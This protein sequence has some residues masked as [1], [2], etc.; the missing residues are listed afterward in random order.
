[1][2]LAKYLEERREFVNTG[3]KESLEVGENRKLVEAMKH[4]PLV[5]GKRLRP[6]LSMLVA[7]AISGSGRKTIQFGLC[8][9]LIH[10]FTLVHDDI[11]DKDELRR[12]IKTVYVVYGTETAINAGDALFARAFE[13]LSGTDVSDEK[14]RLLLQD[15]SST[16]RRV[17]EGQQWDMD[18]EGRKEIGEDEYLRMIE[19][20]TAILYELAAKGGA[21]IAGGTD[22]QVRN[23]A[24]YGRLLGVGFQIW[25]DLLD[26]IGDPKTRGKPFGSDVRN[27]KRTLIVLRTLKALRGAQ[28]K[29][30]LSVLGNPKA[31]DKRVRDEIALM[32]S[33]G[34]I[35]H[36]KRQALSYV[37][38]A[39]RKLDVLPETKYRDILIEFAD[40]M[41][42]REK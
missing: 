22:E 6:I 19:R 26:L 33:C 35:N 27:G 36:A 30:F 12:G 15:V 39:K 20:K 1:M 34:A 25:D 41:V 31:S 5:G 8:L 16:V 10:N 28:K 32:G 18:Y 4:Y 2:E 42:K 23:M 29:E 9:E 24:E 17:A 37:G 38:D 40:F 3:L 7:D 13:V 14:L 21:I 11:M